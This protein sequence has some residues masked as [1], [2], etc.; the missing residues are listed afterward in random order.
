MFAAVGAVTVA[1]AGVANAV[2][3]PGQTATLKDPKAGLDDSKRAITVLMKTAAG[4]G[5]GVSGNPATSTGATLS[6]ITAA[7]SQCFALPA[8]GWSGD[9]VKGFKYKGKLVPGN[10]AVSATFK[11]SGS[12]VFQQKTVLKGKGGPINDLHV[13]NS[14]NVIFNVDGNATHYCTNFGGTISKNDAKL[15]KAV[16]APAP[17]ACGPSACAGACG[18][19]IVNAGEA[20]DTGGNSA[21][22]DSD[23]TAPACGDG[24]HNAAAGEFCDTGTDTAGCDAGDCSAP[25]CG[26]GYFNSAAGEACDSG[27]VDTAGC[28]GATCTLPVCGDSHVNA[29]AG[30]VCDPNGSSFGAG[31]PTDNGICDACLSPSGAFL[32]WTF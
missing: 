16:K 5:P 24:I 17:G 4:A 3:V 23:C 27:G 29:P 13:A 12:G 9:A 25:A 8:A 14:A 18:N 19:S 10:P 7:G 15:F 22:C 26:D 31:P 32:N 21:T 6:I 1:M 11:Q 20:C 30:E 2:T 28:N